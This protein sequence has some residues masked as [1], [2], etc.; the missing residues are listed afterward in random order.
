MNNTQAWGNAYYAA[1]DEPWKLRGWAELLKKKYPNLKEDVERTVKQWN[2]QIRD[3]LRN[4][5][6]LR[7]SIGTDTSQVAVKVIDG[8]PFPLTEVLREHEELAPLLLHKKT[9]E[10]TSNGLGVAS[11]HI[12]HL[13]RVVKPYFEYEELRCIQSWLK[14]KRLAN[15]TYP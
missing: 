7:L 3:H 9:L 15:N 13:A 6:A 10:E 8:F 12:D 5:T 11:K 4:E 14:G 1:E 2:L